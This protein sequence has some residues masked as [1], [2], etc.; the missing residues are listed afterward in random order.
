M[1]RNKD[2]AHLFGMMEGNILENGNK[3]NKMVLDCTK[4]LLENIDMENGQK[5]KESDGWT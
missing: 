1:I 4:L 2:W 5:V 3:G